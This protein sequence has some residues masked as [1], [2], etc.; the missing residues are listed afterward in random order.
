MSPFRVIASHAD[1]NIV[2]S[3]MLHT[4]KTSGSH[5][6]YVVRKH[7]D[8]T[9]GQLSWISDN[10]P[11]SEL[12]RTAHKVTGRCNSTILAGYSVSWDPDTL[13]YSVYRCNRQN[14]AE[15]ELI[16]SNEYTLS[17]CLVSSMEYY[18]KHNNLTILAIV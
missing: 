1:E 4:D 12:R 11:I 10:S 14:I 6:I 5:K 16:T 7:I 9:I 2:L 8:S 13:R 17:D 18:C 15:K 3:S